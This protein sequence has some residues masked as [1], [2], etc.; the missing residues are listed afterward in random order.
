MKASCSS[1]FTFFAY[2]NSLRT[3]LVR[4]LPAKISSNIM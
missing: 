2:W 1:C 4:I 3:K